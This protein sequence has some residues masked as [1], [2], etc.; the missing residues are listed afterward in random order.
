VRDKPWLEWEGVLCS[1]PV[2]AIL[3]IMWKVYVPQAS[4]LQLQM[5]QQI[6]KRIELQLSFTFAMD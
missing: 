5:Y 1:T 2:Q 3:P 4:I 6:M